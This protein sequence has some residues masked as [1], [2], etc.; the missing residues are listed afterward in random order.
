MS[1][2]VGYATRQLSG[3]ATFCKKRLQMPSCSGIPRHTPSMGQSHQWGHCTG[4]SARSQKGLDHCPCFP[5]V[6]APHTPLLDH[7]W[8]TP[9]GAYFC[10]LSI[11]IAGKVDDVLVQVLFI[12]FHSHWSEC[13][14]QP[15][16]PAQPQVLNS[17]ALYPC[18]LRW[19]ILLCWDILSYR[20]AL[21]VIE[22]YEGVGYWP[23]Y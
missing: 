12:L 22:V 6:A 16:L 3:C 23:A 21:L 7:P 1:H 13:I 19:L 14:C 18:H 2:S 4:C 8:V 15:Q 17:S 11:F 5:M 20:F 10:A 9:V